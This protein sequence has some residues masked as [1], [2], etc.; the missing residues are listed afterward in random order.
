MVLK[1][2]LFQI[3][4]CQIHSPCSKMA[5]LWLANFRGKGLVCVDPTSFNKKIKIEIKCSFPKIDY[6]PVFVST[7]KIKGE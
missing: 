3:T 4:H 2:I 5:P 1:N 6:E 7:H